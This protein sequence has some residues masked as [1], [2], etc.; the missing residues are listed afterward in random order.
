MENKHIVVAFIGLPSAGKSTLLNSLIGKRKYQ[1]G[2]NRTTIKPNQHDD[3]IYDDDENGFIGMDLPGICDSEDNKESDFNE[4]TDAY[5]KNADLIY[6]VTD[7]NHAFITSHEVDEFNRIRKNL[8]KHGEETLTYYQFGIILTKCASLID[9]NN[10]EKFIKEVQYEDGEIT[11]DTEEDTTVSDVVKRVKSQYPDIHTTIFNAH[12]RCIHHKNSS[13][14]LKNYVEKKFPTTNNNT[15][16]SISWALSGIQEKNRLFRLNTVISLGVVK[17]CAK[18]EDEKNEDIRD[19]AI[20]TFF[21]SKLTYT[22]FKTK[23]LGHCRYDLKRDTQI[24]T[25]DGARVQLVFKWYDYI[26]SICKDIVVCLFNKD[27][28]KR[29]HSLEELYENN[30]LISWA[31]KYSYFEPLHIGGL[32]LIHRDVVSLESDA[33]FVEFKKEFNLFVDTKYSQEYKKDYYESIYPQQ[34]SGVYI[35]Y[36]ILMKPY[37]GFTMEYK[38]LKYTRICV[39]YVKLWTAWTS[40]DKTLYGTYYG[41]KFNNSKKERQTYLDFCQEVFSKADFDDLIDIG[42]FIQARCHDSTY[43]PAREALLE[44]IKY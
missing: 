15:A 6:W 24:Y 36:G 42:E 16:F 10:E 39:A 13:E 8:I 23:Y 38:N 11:S 34:T 41:N 12:G 43:G 22:E 40:R 44:M 18:L 28:T 14:H 25:Y 21:P 9:M 32:K 35:S 27:E 4:I 37:E 26:K 1:S 7:S 17:G 5:I 19:D 33:V 20:N 2:V 31:V 3:I 30:K 29:V